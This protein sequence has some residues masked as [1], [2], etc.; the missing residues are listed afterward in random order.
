MN[1]QLYEKP[2]ESEEGEFRSAFLLP[3]HY[4]HLQRQNY[5][6]NAGVSL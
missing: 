1:K 3:D 2:A 6:A 4:D 5:L